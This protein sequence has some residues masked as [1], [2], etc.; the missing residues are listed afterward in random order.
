MRFC[1]IAVR[2]CAATG[3]LLCGWV[4]RVEASDLVRIGVGAV[5]PTYAVFFAG[6]A[7]GFYKNKNLDVEI[8]TFRGGPAT[9]E[10][11]AAGSVDLSAIAPAAVS[12]AVNKGVREKIVALFAPPT[13]AGWYIMVPTASP[14]HT[15]ADLNGKTVAVTQKGSLTDFW[16]NRVARLSGIS[17]NT[18][19]LGGGGVLP[20]LKAKQVDAAIL[21]PLYSYKGI[22]D[23]SLRPVVDLGAKL[24]PSISEGVAASDE[25]IEKKPDVL[26]R[27]LSATAKTLAYMQGHEDWSVKFLGG[28][29]DESDPRVLDMVYKEFIMKIHADGNM[30]PD[31][32][33]DSLAN[34]AFTG[35][36]H[37][38]PQDKVF[39]TAFVPIK[40]Q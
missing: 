10:A 9:Q 25:L 11:L 15:V 40:A 24:P 36:E 30:Q 37:A 38:L 27:W 16:V 26:K 22:V 7:L 32:M 17:V 23:G 39:T 8:T 14:I 12:L 35:G 20:G 4:G 18:I 3:L 2:V 19:P 21:W 1:S 5:Y 29:F 13:A 28:Y 6:N 33:K 31:W 34:D